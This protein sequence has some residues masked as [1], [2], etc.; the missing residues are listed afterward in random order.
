MVS[1][2]GGPKRRRDRRCVSEAALQPSLVS[3]RQVD[4]GT[5]VPYDPF[6]VG[7]ERG[8]RSSGS[9]TIFDTTVLQLTGLNWG[10][11]GYS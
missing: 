3:S 7:G 8:V 1:H 11:G 9:A 4:T 2:L 5:D 6:G 10:D